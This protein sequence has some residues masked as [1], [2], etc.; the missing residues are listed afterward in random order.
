MMPPPP[1]FNNTPSYAM[2][3]GGSGFA[4]TPGPSFCG[5]SQMQCVGVNPLMQRPPPPPP[6]PPP[7][8]PM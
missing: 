6:P 3:G 2:S 4:T 1:T 8:F 5:G 7:M